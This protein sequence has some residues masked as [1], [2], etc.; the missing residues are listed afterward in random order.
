MNIYIVTRSVMY[1]GDYI[2]AVYDSFEAASIVCD[3]FNR[4]STEVYET[5]FVETHEVICS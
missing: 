3:T 5:Y 4:G 1:E 2:E